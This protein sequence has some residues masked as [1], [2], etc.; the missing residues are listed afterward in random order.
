MKSYLRF[1]MFLPVVLLLTAC[2]F[3]LASDITPPPGYN[4]PPV[5]T[6]SAP[7]SGPLFP[8][9]APNPDAGAPI[10]A[11]DCAPC[12]GVTGLGDGPQAP[13]L[14]NPPAALGDPAVA[15][16]ASPS[17]WYAMVTE[18]NLERFMPPFAS[19]TARQRWDVV[20][21][22]FTLSH[23]AE[24]VEQGSELYAQFCS[25]C[26]GNQGQGDGPDAAGLSVDLPDFSNQE[27][28][29]QHSQQEFF[30]VVS[31]GTQEMPSFSD[32]LTEEQRWAVTTYLRTMHF[33]QVNVVAAVTPAPGE[34]VVEPE[35]TEPV[36]STAQVT[37]TEQVT[38]PVTAGIVSGLVTNASGGEVPAGLDVTLHGF[39]E[40]QIVLTRT[41]QVDAD[42]TYRF[43]D[44]PLDPGRSYLTTLEYEDA[45]YGSSFVTV[46]DESSLDLPV[47]IY[48]STTDASAVSIDRLHVFFE[49]AN[50]ETL[51]V[52]ELYILSNFGD[53]IVVPPEEGEPTITFTLPEGATNL[54]FQDGVLGGR[55]VATSDGFGD[56]AVIRPGMGAYEIL[57]AYEMPYDGSLEWG[58]PV[59]FPVGAVVILAPEGS[60]RIESD[61]L[62]AAESRDVQG[63]SYQIYN[64]PALDAGDTLELTIQRQ[65]TL[66]SSLS[67]GSSSE[68]VIGVAALGAVLILAGIF[69]YLRSLREEAEVD[70]EEFL[71][72][73]EDVADEDA[74]SLMDRILTLDDLY[75]GGQLPQDAYRQR[76][77]EL[78]D[79]LRERLEME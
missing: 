76:R 3:S 63:V 26:H 78:K 8:L 74:E 19:L 59:D 49:L 5:L 39:E 57:Y 14:P 7:V 15:R 55:Y 51:R 22:A 50:D 67:L 65:S 24:E 46:E 60:V 54:E 28:M 43:E 6:Q 75:R 52:I 10:Y 29:A 36:T 21:Y 32:Q 27:Y 1:L 38:V 18:G 42:R 11:E 73:E 33:A 58:H 2:E 37:A 79:R 68:L 48:D 69:M 40:M 13:Q 34:L 20:A 70:E 45:T 62:I 77:A 64:A 30:Q 72:L 4:P 71:V 25:E 53:K 47:I 23:A 44:V 66:S 31:D 12:H 16:V 56:T 17:D 61:D 35:P 41:T 9:V